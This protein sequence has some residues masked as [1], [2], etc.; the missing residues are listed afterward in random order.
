VFY[1]SKL[2]FSGARS[3]ASITFLEKFKNELVDLPIR[4]LIRISLRALKEATSEAL[5]ENT[6]DVAVVGNG[7]PFRVLGKDEISKVLEELP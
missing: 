6:C 7:M 1:K 2:I 3:N 5:T 4:E